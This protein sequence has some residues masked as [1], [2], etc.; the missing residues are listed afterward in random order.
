MNLAITG[1][2]ILINGKSCDLN[3]TYVL[4]KTVIEV[5]IPTK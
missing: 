4:Y 1:F 3:Q 2:N 5:Q